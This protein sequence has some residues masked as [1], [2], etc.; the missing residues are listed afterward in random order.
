MW[1]LGVVLFV[2]LAGYP[3]FFSEYPEELARLISKGS[4]DLECG[5]WASISPNAKDLV[6]R[7]LTVDNRS[8][9]TAV[10]CLGHSWFAECGQATA[11][12]PS[13]GLASDESN[14]F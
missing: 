9:P 7:L 14:S 3:P 13:A 12:S 11:P 6:Q 8:R 5:P 1:S 10:E 2:L 4:V